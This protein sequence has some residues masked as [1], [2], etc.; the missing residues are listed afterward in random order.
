MSSSKRIKRWTPDECRELVHLRAEGATYTALAGRFDTTYESIRGKLALMYAGD[1]SSLLV[2]ADELE[3]AKN[4]SW[5]KT[6][7]AHRQRTASFCSRQE[8]E[9]IE[10][11]NRH[12]AE[13][14]LRRERLAKLRQ[15]RLRKVR[16]QWGETFGSGQ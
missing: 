2:D 4:V 10:A 3:K 14:L 15:E 12:V 1:S 7:A 11:Y 5:K 6:P 13:L 9:I 8:K 16:A